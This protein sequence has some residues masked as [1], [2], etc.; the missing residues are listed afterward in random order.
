MEILPSSPLRRLLSFSSERLTRGKFPFVS[1]PSSAGCDKYH[2]REEQPVTTTL[3]RRPSPNKEAKKVL[4]EVCFVFPMEMTTAASAAGASV[5]PTPSA[6][7]HQMPTST[8]V[9]A[10]MTT[11]EN[12]GIQLPPPPPAHFRTPLSQ[13]LFLYSSSSLSSPHPPTPA[14]SLMTQSL[15]PGTHQMGIDQNRGSEASSQV[16]AVFPQHVLVL[17]PPED[18]DGCRL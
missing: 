11:S 6:Q 17:P 2:H 14:P 5:S 3:G 8:G 16:S 12:L 18:F 13:P 15:I 10:V 7:P 9:P 1:L 4:K